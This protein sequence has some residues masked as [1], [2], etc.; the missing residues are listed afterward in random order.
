MPIY[1]A[2]GIISNN[3]IN[4]IIITSVMVDFKWQKDD[5]KKTTKESLARPSWD[6]YFMEIAKLV[7]R[8]ATCLRRKVGAIIVKDRRILATGYNGGP[9]KVKDC[10]ELGCLRD[11]YKIKSG[12]NH[13]ICR[14]IHAEQNA[15]IQAA[16]HGVNISGATLYNTHSPCILCAKMIVNAN[17][18]KF[19]CNEKYPDDEGIKLLKESGI[20]IEIL[21]K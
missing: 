13:E 3:L 9:K 6:E 8:R 4:H 17:I 7:A 5:G 12:T 2:F 11:E 19:V 1:K 21:E 20:K 15:I 16:V 14:A 18:A 10:L